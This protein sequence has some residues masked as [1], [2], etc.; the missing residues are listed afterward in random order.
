MF[1]FT[2]KEVTLDPYSQKVYRRWQVVLY[3]AT[4]A[5][6]VLLTYLIILAP[7]NFSFN[8][9]NPDSN[10]NN[11]EDP[12]WKNDNLFFNT[13]I[14]SDYSNA[15]VKI[16]L[17]EK[18]QDKFFGKVSV[19]RSYQAF[20]YDT[21]EPFGF[22]DEKT[23]DMAGFSD[24]ALVSN[25]DSVYILSRGKFFPIDSALTFTEKGYSWEDVI[26]VGSDV[27]ATLEKEKIFTVKV[28]H[29]DG[30]IFKTKESGK[31]YLI[32]DGQKHLLPSAAAAASWNK[33]HPILV[34]EKSLEITA[35]CQPEKNLFSSHAYS[36]SIPLENLSDLTG[37]NYEFGLAA[38]SETEIFSLSVKYK[39]SINKNNLKAFLVNTY[40]ALRT[41]YNT[42]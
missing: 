20:M 34:D 16:V 7:K 40:Y 41:N 35:S 31:Y 17:E 27:L 10:D 2:K 33:M 32:W 38:P 24:G 8:F 37:F 15:D 18:N 22:R 3:S 28:P 6:G 4:I 25:G 39:K 42:K 11:I 13:N 21:G 19:R 1:D 23:E 29:P 9:G 5:A 26:P 36:C 30:T 12:R 14:T